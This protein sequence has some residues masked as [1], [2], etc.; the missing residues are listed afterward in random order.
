[1][2]RPAYH[3]EAKNITDRTIIEYLRRY[4]AC[5]IRELVD[6]AGV[7]AT[8]IRQR[9]NRLMEQGLIVRHSE[10]SGRGRPTH[11]Y[12]LSPT[13]IRVGG[14]NFE[15]LA[16]ALWAELHAV[17]DPEVRNGLLNR[18][19]GRLSEKYVNDLEGENLEEKLESLTRLMQEKDIPFEIEAKDGE[20]P[21]LTALACPYPN[22]AEH[23]R[24]IC[25]ME[26]KVFSE[27]L[28]KNVNLTSCRL[29]GDNCCTFEAG[30]HHTSSVPAE[31]V[32]RLE[33]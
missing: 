28:G 3:P 18:V 1:M 17:K 24:S 12:S 25:S 11:R 19:I 20:L 22:L 31:P 26:E 7:T 15:D 21:V 13:G 10:T 9:V 32:E 30:F 4:E 23:D 8:A 16:K 14:D 6:Y 33:S 29:D 5:S 2:A 27:M